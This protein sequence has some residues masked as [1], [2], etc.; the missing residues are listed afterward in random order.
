MMCCCFSSFLLLMSLF[1]PSALVGSVR[2]AKMHLPI[3]HSASA[4]YNS[5][6]LQKNYPT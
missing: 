3:E 4:I 5:I 6:R 1:P 2:Q